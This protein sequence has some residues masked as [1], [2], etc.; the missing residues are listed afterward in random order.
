MRERDAIKVSRFKPEMFQCT[1]GL[2]LQSARIYTLQED[3]SPAQM[4]GP[5]ILT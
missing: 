5:A 1:V 4:Y 3:F 2:G